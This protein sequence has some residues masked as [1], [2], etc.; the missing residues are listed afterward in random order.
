[1]GFMKNKDLIAQHNARYYQKLETYLMKMNHF[2]DTTEDEFSQGIN[3]EM[4]EK[5]DINVVDSNQTLPEDFEHTEKD[6]PTSWD[7]RAQGAVTAVKNQG[8][9][10]SC[11]SFAA[12]G[13]MEAANFLKSGELRSLSEQQLLDC[14]GKYYPHA[15]EK[16]DKHP[17]KGGWYFW[18]FSYVK[19]QGGINSEEDYP[20][21]AS[22]QDRKCRYDPQKYKGTVGNYHQVPAGKEY[23][24]KEVVAT[25]M[26]VAVA[27][28]M[29]KPDFQNYK[30]YST[31]VFEPSDCPHKS[32]HA[33]LVVGY[34]ITS[35]GQKYWLIKNSWGTGWGDDGYMKMARN[36]DNMCAIS[37]WAFY[38]E[39]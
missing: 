1:M 4:M 30:F 14:V 20:Y 31:G 7:W 9:C 25:K 2:G 24:L 29:K 15:K 34:G 19:K 38:A 23:D 12:T 5:M 39:A 17:C 28:G 6:L 37:N 32:N 36:H 18:A 33:V 21:H 35:D 26:P 16:L 8:H 11:W 3:Q 22:N 10:G 27:I 13:V